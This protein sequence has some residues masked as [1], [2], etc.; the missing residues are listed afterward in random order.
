MSNETLETIL[1]SIK[2]EID[3]LRAYMHA[4]KTFKDGWF[5]WIQTIHSLVAERCLYPQSSPRLLWQA[6]VWAADTKKELQF[7]RHQVSR[8]KN[9]LI[10]LNEKCSR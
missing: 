8:T 1:D 7:A 6:R 5:R 9:R 10:V 3:L 2:E 4:E